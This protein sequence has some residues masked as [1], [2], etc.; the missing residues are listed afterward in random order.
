MKDIEDDR[1]QLVAPTSK[2]SF[3]KRIA[4]IIAV[5]S[6]SSGLVLLGIIYGLADN[7]VCRE[8]NFLGK[9][10]SNPFF[11][12]E[13][14]KS[15]KSYNVV[16]FGDSLINEPFVLNNLAGKMSS[17]LPQYNLNIANYGVNGDNIF[18]MRYS[19]IISLVLFDFFFSS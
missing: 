15:N 17:F 18:L 16:L 8:E 14:A 2:V 19:F 3:Y 12:E 13:I 4:F 6:I 9:G 7:K 11:N 5:V 1:V 10:Y